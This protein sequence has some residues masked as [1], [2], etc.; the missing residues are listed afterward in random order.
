VCAPAKWASDGAAR[1]SGALWFRKSED[2]KRVGVYFGYAHEGKKRKLPMGTYDEQGVCGLTL[3]QCR[4]KYGGIS[5]VYQ[6]GVTDLHAHYERERERTERARQAE[7]E[8][9][10]QAAEE[11]QRGALRQLLAARV[12]Y[13]RP[14]TWPS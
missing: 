1:G 8:A 5:R 12:S 14:R 9:A 13:L 6:S 7:A 3:A 10:R 2:G 11:A 4:E